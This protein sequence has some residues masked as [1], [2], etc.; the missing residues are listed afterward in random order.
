VL[1]L[2]VVGNSLEVVAWRVVLFQPGDLV[3]G[4]FDI[5]GGRGVVDVRPVARADQWGHHDGIGPKP[6]QRDLRAT[7]AALLRDGADRA[8]DR[9]VTL[10]GGWRVQ[11]VGKRVVA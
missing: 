4:E 2:S 9:A 3:A 5:E 11:H 7:G 6:R 1:E 8:G 10:P